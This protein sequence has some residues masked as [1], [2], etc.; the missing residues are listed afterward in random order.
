MIFRRLR[1]IIAS[2]IQYDYMVCKI[3][4]DNVKCVN[5]I[6]IHTIDT[7]DN[8]TTVALPKAIP[9]CA[10]DKYIQAIL[11]INSYKN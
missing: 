11:K 7:A 3:E 10:K 5:A 1:D 9:C 4:N 2:A 6:D 8:H